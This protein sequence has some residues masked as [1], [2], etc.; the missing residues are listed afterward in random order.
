M[1]VNPNKRF[2]RIVTALL[3]AVLIF[4]IVPRAI[5]IYD[6]SVR[7]NALLGQKEE[8]NRINAEHKQS[9]AEINTPE[10]IE[11][12]AREKLGMVKPG[13]RPIIKV[14]PNQ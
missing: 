12:I 10:G 3:C 11:R 4:T 8:L 9:L 13:E 6:L 2:R 7:K 5:T 1:K 14:I